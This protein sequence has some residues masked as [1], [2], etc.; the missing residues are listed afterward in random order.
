MRSSLYARNG[1][2]QPNDNPDLL[3]GTMGVLSDGRTLIHAPPS[4]PPDADMDVLIDGSAQSWNWDNADPQ[5]HD[6]AGAPDLATLLP[7]LATE[8]RAMPTYPHSWME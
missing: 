4:T 8:I 2:P 3:L 6:V 7:S 5:P 1:A